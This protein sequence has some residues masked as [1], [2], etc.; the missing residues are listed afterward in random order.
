MWIILS[1]QMQM[2]VEC[3][4]FCCHQTADGDQEQQQWKS[5]MR[6]CLEEYEQA[7]KEIAQVRIPE[8]YV[9]A[10]IK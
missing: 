7:R 2:Q 5:R 8:L 6:Q 9:L 3:R 1:K 10:P 4:A